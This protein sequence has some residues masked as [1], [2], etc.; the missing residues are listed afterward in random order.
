[1]ATSD[2]ALYAGLREA[3]ATHQQW[4]TAT[5]RYQRICTLSRYLWQRLG[6][7]PQITRLKTTPP[8]AGLVS[9]QV[10]G[11]THKQFV[12]ALEQQS[13]M[14][15]TILDPDC[16]RACVHYFTLEAEIDRLIEAI[17]TLLKN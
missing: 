12:D 5:E 11:T 13:L 14:L 6:E 17:A 1:V 3:I 10:S 4:G 15:R 8:A 16:V 9:F 2:F 7:F